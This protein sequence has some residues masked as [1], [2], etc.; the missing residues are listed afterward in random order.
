MAIDYDELEKSLP[1]KTREG[2]HPSIRVN[3]LRELPVERQRLAL[4]RLRRIVQEEDL[5]GYDSNFVG[6][7]NNECTWGACSEDKKLWPDVQDYVWPHDEDRVAPL[8]GMPCPLDTGPDP[9]MGRSGCFYRCRFFRSRKFGLP[10][11]EE[12]LKRIDEM[13]KELDADA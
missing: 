12:V 4:E 3:V 7:K 13:L 11:R 2:A 5:N 1:F 9:E 10:S 8:S 6:D